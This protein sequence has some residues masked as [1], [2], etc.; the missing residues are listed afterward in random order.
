MADFLPPQAIEA[1]QAVLGAMLI[2]KESII[3]CLDILK[4]NDFYSSAHQ[5]V[6]QIISYLYINNFPVELI[7]VNNEMKNDKVLQDIGGAAFLIN[8]TG[9]VSTVANVDHYARIVKEK[10][11][12]RQIAI[13]GM[14]MSNA[15][16]SECKASDILNKAQSVIYQVSE[17][18]MTRGFS[19]MKSLIH[20]MIDRV[21]NLLKDKKDIPGLKT[22][23]TNL[24][25]MTAGLQPSDLILIAGRPSMGKTAFALNIAANVALNDNKPVAIFSLEMSKESLA[26]RLS[27]STAK[28]DAHKTRQGFLESSQWAKFT[29]TASQLYDT[30]LYI[31]DSPTINV[32]EMRTRA[33]KLATELKV[34]GKELSLIIIDYIQLMQGIGRTENRQ[35]EMAEIS[36]SLKG[37]A[38]D[39]NIPVIAISQLSRKTEE[40]GRGHRPQLSDLRESGAL[41]QDADV[42]AFVYRE[43][44]YKRDDPDLKYKATL[45]LSKQRNGPTAD[46]DLAFFP[47]YTRFEN[48]SK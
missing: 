15:A 37:L 19:P 9:K 10:S 34:Q 23:F 46:I 29:T 8:M 27:C 4:D 13:I 16:Q 44:Y 38:R 41:E 31:D 45:I 36:R 12:L 42:V 18:S 30:P 48:A 21:E 20:P 43:G 25:R 22:G 28:V 5:R 11:I 39:L 40:H 33:R 32:M 2:D 7:S 26:L 17:N 6:F 35:Q 1:E 47:E 14:E 3:K 24:D